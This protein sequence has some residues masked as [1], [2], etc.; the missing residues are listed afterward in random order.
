MKQ[1]AGL[2][3]IACLMM[4]SCGRDG[5][6]DYRFDPNHAVWSSF[7]GEKAR[8]HCAALVEFGPR[9]AGSPALERSRVYLEKQLTALGWTVQRQVF[10]AATPLRSVEFVNLRARFGQTPFSEPVRVLIGSHYDTK[11]FENIRF[12]GAND[13]GSSSG[14]LLEMARV[15]AANPALASAV[16]LVFF[17]GEEAVKEFSDTDGI[18]GS[19]YY[20][21]EIVRRQPKRDRPK[22][23]L[24]LDMI[25]DPDLYVRLPSDTPPALADGLFQAATDAGTRS[26]F[27]LRP[28][29]ILDDHQPFQVEGVPSIDLID[30]DFGPWHTSGDTMDQVSAQSL[31]IVGRTALLF[32]ERHLLAP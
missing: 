6:G 2:W 32:L 13:G 4:T 27:G 1:G 19:R 15:M 9:P 14:A 10:T 16:E 21:R 30:L 11:Y 18:Y 7:S 23:V 25:G 24:V 8:D 26:S 12:V 29:P 22:A 5:A 3:A 31:E 20:A 17:D 28:T